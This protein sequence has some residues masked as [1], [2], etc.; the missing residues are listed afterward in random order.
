MAEKMLITQALDERDLL[1]KKIGDKIRKNS[2]V[3]TKK[4][5]ADIIAEQKQSAE[6]FK[7]EAESTFQ[8]IQDLIVANV[9]HFFT[10]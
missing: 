7:K 1:V 10:R 5:N 3:A 2:F 9:N 8:S 6:E 4:H